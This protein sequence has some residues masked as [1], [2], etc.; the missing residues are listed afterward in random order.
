M[1]EPIFMGVDGGGTTTRCLLVNAA[2]EFLGYGLGGPA[3]PKSVGLSVA[4]D[5]VR[6]AIDRAWRQSAQLKRSLSGVFLGIAGLRT[7]HDQAAFDELIRPYL[8][9]RDPEV[10]KLGHDLRTAHAAAL[11]G[12]EGMILISGTGSACFGCNA[13]GL[14]ARSGGWGWFIDD[15]GSGYWL[16]L[17]AM[18]AMARQIDGRGARTT[19]TEKVKEFFHLREYNE[20]PNI[21]YNPLFSRERIAE[22]APLVEAEAK[23]GDTVAIAIFN[24]GI[25]EL[26]HMVRAVADQ[27]SLSEKEYCVA[28]VGGMMKPGS[29]LAGEMQVELPKELPGAQFSLS[30]LD[31]VIGAL[32]LAL[33]NAGLSLTNE[34]ALSLQLRL[35]IL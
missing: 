32:R 14:E 18:R 26:I 16:G 27:L 31:P 28:G 4:T 7:I 12:K 24:E 19:L 33:K 20:L 2:G 17:H 11:N 30:T 15:P 5:S 22:L 9:L 1:N 35:K 3:N 29:Y 23:A 25:R 34:Q 13:D 10:L 21:I 6:D 8:S